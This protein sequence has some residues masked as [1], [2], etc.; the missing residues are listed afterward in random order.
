[1]NIKLIWHML[2]SAN[3]QIFV[4]G[5]Y[6]KLIGT[7]ILKFRE[8]LLTPF[9]G[10]QADLIQ[11]KDWPLDLKE[12]L[13]KKTSEKLSGIASQ[14]FTLS[15]ICLFKCLRGR[16]ERNFGL[17]EC[18]LPVGNTKVLCCLQTQL[19]NFRGRYSKTLDY[20]QRSQSNWNMWRTVNLN[21]VASC[22]WPN[23]FS[24]W[25][26]MIREDENRRKTST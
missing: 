9:P 11:Y 14:L 24:Q 23:T 1:M 6:V 20:S 18:L 25:K 5:G 17:F 13:L 10:V 4:L 15:N 22:F 21:V 26:H 12:V 2:S 8:K 3:V 19:L 16:L 7:W